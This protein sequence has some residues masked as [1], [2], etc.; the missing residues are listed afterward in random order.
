MLS[1]VGDDEASRL[2]LWE[3]LVNDEILD[4]EIL[5]GV[6]GKFDAAFNESD[7]VRR[8]CAFPYIAMNT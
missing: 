1:E 4:D 8:F 3:S 5:D 2:L 6:I 7:I